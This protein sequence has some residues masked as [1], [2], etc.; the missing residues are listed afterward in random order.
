M[1]IAV[2][3]LPGSGKSYFARELAKRIDA[4]Y[5]SSDVIRKQLFS[6]PSYSDEEKKKVY[7]ELCRIM[8]DYLHCRQP[9]VLD[10]TFFKRDIR[11]QFRQASN[12]VGC[13]I[14]WIEIKAS[15]QTVRNRLSTP[16]TNSDADYEV[17]TK[18]REVFQPMREPH[19][20]LVSTDDNLDSMIGSALDYL[21][22]FKP[23]NEV[24]AGNLKSIIP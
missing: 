22:R 9:L 18:I 24:K 5:E 1:I 11:A 3:G 7:Q 4:H 21:E 12:S 17:H 13:T 23:R 2:F 14:A 20:V 16:R 10:A 15:D 19:L 8:Y 6:D